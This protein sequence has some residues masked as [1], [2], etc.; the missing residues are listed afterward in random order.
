MGKERSE[1]C[2]EQQPL[3]SKGE[4]NDTHSATNY[5]RQRHSHGHCI[6][7]YISEQID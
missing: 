7:P 2:H 3:Q 5:G 4:G 6:C 1:L